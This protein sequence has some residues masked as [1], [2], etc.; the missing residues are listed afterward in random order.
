[1]FSL[2]YL[3]QNGLYKIA[4]LEEGFT[5][6]STKMFPSRTFFLACTFGLVAV[7]VGQFGDGLGGVMKKGLEDVAKNTPCGTEDL[8]VS[9]IT[10]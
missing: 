7:A 5:F 2:L 6:H 9:F 3:P 1:M 10:D 8:Q 4:S